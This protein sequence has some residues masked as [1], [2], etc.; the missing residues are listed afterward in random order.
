MVTE[1]INIAPGK[2]WAEGLTEQ[3]FIA[4][5]QRRFK[6]CDSVP[7]MHSWIK[8]PYPT[9]HGI[10]KVNPEDIQYQDTPGKAEQ[11]KTEE[12]LIKENSRFCPGCK[13]EFK[14]IKVKGVIRPNSLGLAAHKKACKTLLLV[15]A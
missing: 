13:R 12:D 4:E 11:P 15:K 3:E 14:A 7:N 5:F 1:S 10:S 2:E 6:G 9:Y 8:K